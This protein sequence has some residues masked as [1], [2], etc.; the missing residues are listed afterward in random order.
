MGFG[1]TRIE[2]A[3]AGEVLRAVASLAPKEALVVESKQIEE[4]T[5][6]R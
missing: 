1:G 2:E 3:G 6:G 4:R 5:E